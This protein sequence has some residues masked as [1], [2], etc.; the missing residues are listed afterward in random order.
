MKK[1]RIKHVDKSYLC[2]GKSSTVYWS[3]MD[4]ASNEHFI[5]NRLIGLMHLFVVLTLSNNECYL[6]ELKGEE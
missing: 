4:G 2:K 6:E 1:Y 3:D 5:H